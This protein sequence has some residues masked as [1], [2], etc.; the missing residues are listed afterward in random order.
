MSEHTSPGD[1]PRVFRKGE[2]DIYIDAGYHDQEWGPHPHVE[3][4]I[5]GTYITGEGGT[6]TVRHIEQGVSGHPEFELTWDE[7][8]DEH[9][10]KVTVLDEATALA[11]LVA[12]GAATV[13]P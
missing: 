11:Y 8:G 4:E 6:I 2:H 5:L 12:D 7:D 1:H 10:G 9:R 13:E 3:S